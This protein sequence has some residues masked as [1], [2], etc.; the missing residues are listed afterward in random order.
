MLALL[1]ALYKVHADTTITM[2]PDL[3]YKNEFI[4]V[5][6]GFVEDDSIIYVGQLI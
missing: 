4:K 1:Q 2:E 6:E 3:L 5:T